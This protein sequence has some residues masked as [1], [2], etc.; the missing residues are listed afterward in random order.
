MT[1]KPYLIVYD[2]GVYLHD[3]LVDDEKKT[4]EEEISKLV[5]SVVLVH[6][7]HFTVTGKL[8]IDGDYFKVFTKGFYKDEIAS[9]HFTWKDVSHIRKGVICIK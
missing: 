8:F 1:D 9:C 6:N 7:W 4:I 3:E 2:F 5:G